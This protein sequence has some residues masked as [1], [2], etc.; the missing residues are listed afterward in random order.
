MTR[1]GSKAQLALVEQAVG[2]VTLVLKPSRLKWTMVLA[3]CLLFAGLGALQIVMPGSMTD[4]V[5]GVLSLLL[6]G[7]G[8]LL[9]LVQLLLGRSELRLDGSGFTIVTLRRAEHFAWSDVT[10]PFGIA[11][12]S[13]RRFVVFSLDRPATR[14]S[15][16]NVAVTG[17]THAL[18][19]TYGLDATDLA[20]SDDDLLA[21]CRR[22]KG[23]CWCRP[24]RACRRT[25]ATL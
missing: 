1:S 5:I 11:V 4:V 6:F 21:A 12:L 7:G 10:G 2:P 17:H 25:V 24:S 14:M 18:P 13:R 8:G 9:V 16:L 19:D 15:R 22:L 20:I 3:V 23:R